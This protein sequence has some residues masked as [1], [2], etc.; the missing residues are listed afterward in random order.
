VVAAAHPPPPWPSPRSIGV[1]VFTDRGHD[2]HGSPD[3]R[4]RRPS[5]DDTDRKV[6]RPLTIVQEEHRRTFRCAERIDELC[7]RLLEAVLRYGP[8]DRQGRREQPLERR[9]DRSQLRRPGAER[10]RQVIGERRVVGRSIEDRSGEPLEHREGPRR[11]ELVCLGAEHSLAALRRGERDLV[12]DPGLA[13]TGLRDQSH[14]GTVTACRAREQLIDPPELVGPADEPRF[15]QRRPKVAEPDHERRIG[16]AGVD[17]AFQLEQV[18]KDARGRGVSI[19]WILPQQTSDDLVEHA[20][21]REAGAA[22][23]A[24]RRE[25]LGTEELTDVH[26]CMQRLTRHALPQARAHRIEIGPGVHRILQHAGLLGRQA[27]RDRE[28]ESATGEHPPRIG[29]RGH[30]V[31]Q[32]RASL[33]T[34]DHVRRC[35][36]AVRVSGGV[37][38]V[39]S[40][41]HVQGDL[42]DPSERHR[43]SLDD[44]A[45]RLPF[46]ERA[47]DPDAA[48]GGLDL[49][50]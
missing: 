45:E 48:R 40:S 20:G 5:V 7:H 49:G 41:E 35:D 30:R 36:G 31:R 13:V 42:E 2:G 39:E 25:H 29:V 4:R 12:E 43:A 50:R 47:E 21:S 9:Q 33:R 8:L 19:P 11:L 22:D 32:P 38:R 26:R 34:H 15:G 14:Q 46:H 16:I 44:G 23:A 10:A 27:S 28:I 18:L 24:P 3:A 37:Q 6:V 17:A 1:R